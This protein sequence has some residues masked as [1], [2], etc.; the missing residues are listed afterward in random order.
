MQACFDAV[1]DQDIYLGDGQ[2]EECFSEDIVTR[3][4]CRNDREFEF[5]RRMFTLQE[6]KQ[7]SAPGSTLGKRK[8]EADEAD[9]PHS[10]KKR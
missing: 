1:I 10:G 5:A 2:Y 7:A 3:P 9:G 8:L 6:K 4:K